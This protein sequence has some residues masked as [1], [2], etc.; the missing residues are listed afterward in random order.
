MD[1]EDIE[2]KDFPITA[3]TTTLSLVDTWW[4]SVQAVSSW[5]ARRPFRQ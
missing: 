3:S 1:G 5:I 4:I 2:R